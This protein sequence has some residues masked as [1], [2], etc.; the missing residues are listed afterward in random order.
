MP[1][2]EQNFI[3]IDGERFE[4]LDEVDNIPMAD[5][6]VKTN[7]LQ[8]TVGHG[9]AKLYV[10][11]QQEKNFN[12]FFGDFSGRAFF[13]KKDLADY[14]EDAKF[15]Y[16]QQEQKYRQDISDRWE[17]HHQRLQNLSNREFF[18]I[19]QAVPQDR[20][21]YYIRS[22]NEIFDFFRSIM[23]PIISYVSILKLKDAG[24]NLLFLFRPSLSYAFNLYYHPAKEREVEKEI[25]EKRLPAETREQLVKARIG[26]GAYRQELLEE[27]SECVITR[28][29]DERIL[30]A[31]HIKPWSVSDD[32]EKI[33]HNNG[34]VL[35]PTYDKLFDQG[36]I[37]FEDDGTVLLS[38]YISPLNLKKLSLVK[39]RQYVIPPS[40]RRKNYL[41]Y[42][43][44]HIF[45]K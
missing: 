27:S 33:D 42:H 23:L 2:N 39:G 11:A 32:D 30:M 26:Q 6:F 24:G 36:F 34:L 31:S 44:D 7:K 4:L 16:E 15:E 18:S 45:K 14:L 13:L 43:R 10:G 22:E 19:A 1:D 38:P 40:E 37:S 25:E 5:S 12:E 3:E 8:G 35:T 41:Q 9:E 20:A 29:N 21:R 17:E 28:V